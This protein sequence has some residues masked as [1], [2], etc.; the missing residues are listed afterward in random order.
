MA[1]ERSLGQAQRRDRRS[2]LAA[3]A[4]SQ[5]GIVSR[6]QALAL[7]FSPSAIDR[8]VNTGQW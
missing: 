7:G 1:N 4:S 2:Q 3:L 6:E 5:Y 8:R